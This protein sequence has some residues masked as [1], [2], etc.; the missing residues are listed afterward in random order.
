MKS[1][2][3]LL[4]VLPALFVGCATSDDGGHDPG[5]DPGD[6]PETSDAAAT[7]EEGGASP[8]GAGEAGAPLPVLPHAKLSFTGQLICRIGTGGQVRCYSRSKKAFTIEGITDVVSLS[9]SPRATCA[10]TKNGDVMCWGSQY[11]GDGRSNVGVATPYTPVRVA[12]L[13]GADALLGGGVVNQQCARVAKTGQWFCWGENAGGQF[14][15][16]TTNEHLVIAPVPIPPDAVA[17]AHG[18]THGCY[19]PSMGGV[20]CAGQNDVGQLGDGTT[21]P[22]LTFGEVKGL[23]GVPVVAL[24]IATCRDC[25]PSPLGRTTCAVLRSGEVRCWGRNYMNMLGDGSN[26]DQFRP[27]RNTIATSVQQISLGGYSA[28][29]LSTGGKVTCW[30]NRSQLG[31]K[32]PYDKNESVPLAK[33]VVEIRTIGISGT[34]ALM[35]GDGVKCWGPSIPVDAAENYTVTDIPGL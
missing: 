35:G 29:S 4:F 15:D 5:H 14:G 26:M 23:E 2:Y 21:V 34:C 12:G 18:G 16:G 17:V 25:T 27:V 11:L 9:S 8:E 13:G 33:D 28:C 31:V 32:L 20:W 24:A 7:S 3:R 6:H 10:L 30:G 1:G 19:A 22:R